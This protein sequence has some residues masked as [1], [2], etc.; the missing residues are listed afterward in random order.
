[1]PTYVYETVP[2]RK[3]QRSKR[4]EIVQRMSEAPLSKHPHTGEAV[5]RVIAEVTVIT[6]AG[7]DGKNEQVPCASGNCMLP[8]EIAERDDGCAG[9]ACGLP[10]G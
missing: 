5:R 4:Y 3:G 6:G 10:P 1:M 9:G 7:K 2:E 8:R